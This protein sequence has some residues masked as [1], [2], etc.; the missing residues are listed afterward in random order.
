[1]IKF[2]IKYTAAGA[3]LPKKELVSAVF[4]IALEGSKILAIKNDRGW[5]IPGGHIEGGETPEEAL[6]REVKEE[7]GAVFSDV[8]LLAVIESDDTDRYKD[9]V[10]LAY[11]TRNFK[12]VEFIPSEDA[13]NEKLWKLE[14]S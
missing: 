6:I 14:S 9:K 12:L 3:T 1:M 8:K 2:S 4:L 5:D 11:T 7:A 13:L 10:M